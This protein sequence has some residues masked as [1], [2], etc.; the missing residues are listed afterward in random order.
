MRE[1]PNRDSVTTIEKDG[2]RKMLHPADVS[3]RFTLLRR[4]VA[5]GLIGLFLLLPW[6]PVGGHP[7]VFLDTA[8]LRFHF[9]GLTLAAQ[10]FWILF[11]CLTGLGF[12]LFFVTA[13]LGRVWCGWTC[14]QTVLLEHVFRRI[15]RWI[16]GPPK[17]RRKLEDAPWTDQGKV[18]RR[19]VK[20]GIYL[21]L[22]VLIAHM[23]LAYFISIPTL[24]A[25][26]LGGPGAHVG[27]FLFIVAF[28]GILYFNF[29][30]F[31]E[32][33][34]LVICPYGRLQSALI[35]DDS[36]I[37]GYDEKRGEPR[38]KATDP[39]NGDCIN[40]YRCVDVCPTGIDIRQGLQM[41]CIGCANCID[42][43][44]EIMRKLDRPEGLV[45]YDSLN[46][47]AGKRRRV[48]RPRILFYCIMGLIGASVFAFA[49]TRIQ[50]GVMTVTR[51]GGSAYYVDETRVRNQFVVRLV[52][53]TN[54]DLDY[55]VAMESSVPGVSLADPSTTVT[56]GPMGEET[57]TV[58]VVYP[59]ADYGEK[60][61]PITFTATAQRENSF[62][63]EETV[64]FLGPDP[65]L[66]REDFGL[67]EIE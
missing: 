52:N 25:W 30:W 66:L 10:D 7:A 51:M 62:V 29:A 37:I 11:F 43:C 41:E 9:F 56:V 28:S 64:E 15:E 67:P 3:G 46:G 31:R 36:V 17:Q 20:H 58:V 54:Q 45:R 19:V 34:C 50:P 5:Y 57:R 33:L 16:D 35:D 12:T 63:L 13:L 60:D 14:P 48:I 4:V 24:Y 42:A 32:Q 23:V 53:K 1:R 61:F 38:G 22:C 8:S 2:S 40:C 6:I 47:L 49:A 26:I 39:K 18:V 27:S 55:A 44:N 65:A 21:L 59:I